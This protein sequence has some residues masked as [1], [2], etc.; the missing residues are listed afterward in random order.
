MP[1]EFPYGS[2]EFRLL[3]LLLRLNP[4]SRLSKSIVGE[5]R[6][7]QLYAELLSH[8]LVKEYDTSFAPTEKFYQMLKEKK[9][10]FYLDFEK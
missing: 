9:L 1:K 8:E 5:L 2:E 4:G 7:G 3:D 6:C 10:G